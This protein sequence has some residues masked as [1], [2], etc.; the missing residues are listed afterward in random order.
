MKKCTIS[1]SVGD[2]RALVAAADGR[3]SFLRPA[4]IIESV[5]A[6]YGL[7]S[8][9]LQSKSR[10]RIVKEARS[11]AML[12]IRASLGWS[13]PQIGRLFGRDHTTVMAAINSVGERLCQGEVEM[14]DR[15][16]LVKSVSSDERKATA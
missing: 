5:A 13:F 11:V 2:L 14:I 7:Q 8:R 4:D 12:M 1:T 15:V 9:E 6:A 16:R 10:V 3:T